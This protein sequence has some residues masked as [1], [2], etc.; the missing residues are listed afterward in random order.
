MQFIDVDYQSELPP[1]PPGL[2]FLEFLGGTKQLRCF[3]VSENTTRAEFMREYA[4][5]LDDCMT[6]IYDRD[7]IMIRQD[8][9]FSLP[10]FYIIGL[11][12]QVRALDYLDIGLYRKISLLLLELRKGMRSVLSINHVDIHYDEKLDKT[13][14]VR[15]A[16]MPAPREGP[17]RIP[18]IADLDLRNYLSKFRL[19]EERETILDFNQRMRDYF[20]DIDL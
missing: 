7:G 3:I 15:W 20:S 11:H 6:P 12:D 18:S 13:C 10:G 14:S 8:A 16:V 17:Q 4:H 9:G 1:D 19:T 5:L 2:R